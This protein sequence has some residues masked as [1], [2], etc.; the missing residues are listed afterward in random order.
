MHQLGRSR[1]ETET[2]QAQ[3]VALQKAGHT[4]QRRLRPQLTP[5]ILPLSPLLR[6]LTLLW[7]K[8]KNVN[9]WEIKSHESQLILATWNQANLVHDPMIRNSCT[10][11]SSWQISYRSYVL[12]HRES[13]R[14]QAI[15]DWESWHHHY[16]ESFPS[17]SLHPHSVKER[18]CSGLFPLNYLLPSTRSWSTGYICA[19]P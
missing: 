12:T 2:Q 7:H 19:D 5:Q 10:K 16:W 8:D 4:L 18:T 3:Q 13:R 1:A 15:N 17:R 6:D 14:G 9:R 11:G